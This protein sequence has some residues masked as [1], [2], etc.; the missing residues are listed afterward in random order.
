M[1]ISLDS[2]LG[3]QKRL[4]QIGETINSIATSVA[5]YSLR[6]LTGGD[7]LAV[8]VRRDSDNTEKDFTVSGVNSGAMVDF[9]NTQTVKPLDIRALESDGDRDGDFQIAS[10]A[11]S[12]RSLGDRQAT[13]SAT[14]DTV[15][16]ANGKY[17][18]QV[19]R[20]SDDAI[21]S[22]TADEVTDGTL[23]AFVGSGNDGFVRTWYDQSVT[24]QGGGTATGN[25]ATQS[26]P[27]NQPKIVTNGALLVDSA[28]LP[29]I[30]FDGTHKLDI[31]FGADLDQP[32]SIFMVHQSDSTSANSN[33]FF[34]STGTGG[35]RSVFDQGSANY[36]LVNHTTSP[37]TNVTFEASG[38]DFAIDTNKNIAVG[39]FNGSSS[40][41]AKNGTAD[42]G[43]TSATNGQN[44]INRLSTIGL[45]APNAN[46]GYDGTMQEFIVYN[47]DQTSNRGAYEANLA[48]YYGITGVPTGG[49]TVNG[50]VTKW[51][52]QVGSNDLVQ[53][54]ANEQPK[55]V[56]SGSVVL[57]T[58]GFGA[59]ELGRFGSS[60]FGQLE[61]T[62]GIT[63]SNSHSFQ[64]VE[65][66]RNFCQTL[67]S[68]TTG[69]NNRIGRLSG[70]TLQVQRG[71]T[72]NFASGI[73]VGSNPFLYTTFLAAD[74]NASRVHINGVE[75]QNTIYGNE[76]GNSTF[77][78]I[79]RG[80]NDNANPILISE[81]ILY[82][83]EQSSRTAIEANINSKYSIF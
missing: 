15:A 23:V 60:I 74:G 44:E 2:A 28:G 39:I 78:A 83:S 80:D 38:S 19:R 72:N 14:G 47:S 81:L 3:R 34:D 1:H 57:N 71:G 12:L 31:D 7:P 52:D 56:S 22:F 45:S 10:A 62:S 68:T 70:D 43:T 67:I 58:D 42:T 66:R 65:Y 53:S 18:V 82:S 69:G 24:D 63:I 40:L 16:A 8:R 49:N 48:D 46:N 35:V 33:E 75:K 4:N 11:Y 17:V 21:K 61:F 41:I 64:Y 25:H 30:D 55:I 77:V 26:T 6:S 5:A 76:T 27:A 73:T 54:T 32:N 20:S 13:V 9:V 79:G 36:R 50:F 59:I 51:Y 37:A 29:E